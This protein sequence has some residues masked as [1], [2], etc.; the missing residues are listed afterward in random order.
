MLYGGNK[1]GNLTFWLTYVLHSTFNITVC[2]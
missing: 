1:I 2:L